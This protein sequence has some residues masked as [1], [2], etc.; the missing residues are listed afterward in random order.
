[1]ARYL[2]GRK[3]KIIEELN[4]LGPV[5]SYPEAVPQRSHNHNV[6]HREVTQSPK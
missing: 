1:M 4:A 3:M 5:A 2:V 6:A